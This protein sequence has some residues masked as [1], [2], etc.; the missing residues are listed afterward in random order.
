[1]TLVSKSNM[2]PIYAN[3]HERLDAVIG[4]QSTVYAPPWHCRHHV[5]SMACRC[6]LSFVGRCCVC[7]PLVSILYPVSQYPVSR[8]ILKP[9]SRTPLS[10][11]RGPLAGAFGALLLAGA[12]GALPLLAGAFGALPLLAGA[13]GAR[14][15]SR[16]APSAHCTPPPPRRA[17]SAQ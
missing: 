12:F 11:V 17:P 5:D 16:W 9:V 15:A 13:F 1:M 4:D 14:T 2:E 8:G 7:V 6:V 3:K 10:L